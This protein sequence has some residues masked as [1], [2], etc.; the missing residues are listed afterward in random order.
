MT[1]C[2]CDNLGSCARPAGQIA[3][4]QPAA[5]AGVSHAP[6]RLRILFV[7]DEA[8]VLEGLRRMLRKQTAEWDMVFVNGGQEA[9]EQ[10]AARPFDVLVTDMQMPG[11]N[12]VELLELAVKQYPETG[13][14]VLSGHINEGFSIRATQLSHQCLAKPTDPDTLKAAIAR[15]RPRQQVG[16]NERA[17]AIVTRCQNLPVLPEFCAELTRLLESDDANAKSIGRVISRDLSMSAKILQ[18]V[19][20]S[21]FGIGRRV[22][23]VEMAVSLLGV[24]RIRALVLHEQIFQSFKDN[25]SIPL[26]SVERLW[27]RS[28]QVAE[29]SR[30]LSKL[31]GQDGDR[32]DQ[33]F[34]AGLL[35]D[36]GLLLLASLHDEFAFVIETIYEKRIPICEAEME[37][38]N[39]T[40]AEMGSYLLSLWGLPARI[41]EAVALHHDPMQLSYDGLCAVTMV[42]AADALLAE[43]EPPSE[44]D[45][46][47]PLL[48]PVLDEQYLQRIGVAE[49]LPL[50]RESV[51]EIC[52]RATE[53]DNGRD[54]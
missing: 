47:V 15:A 45:S 46:I 19:N 2:F 27:H 35:H 30:T 28:L 29:I 51:A 4:Q 26:F 32:P 9:L 43:S 14:I 21:F 36:V 54:Q 40:H 23:S 6:S 18:L 22:S 44:P 39:A 50:W 24:L 7:D 33:A 3:A 25:R 8:G 41:V 37:V 20:S 10:L 16:T 12:G 5:G 49:R 34:T 52:R 13:R 11:I 53:S 48:A 17:R 38:L 1:K 31:E 42:H